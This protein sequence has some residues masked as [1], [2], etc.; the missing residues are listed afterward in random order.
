VVGP[1]FSAAQSQR[2]RRLCLLVVVVLSPDDVDVEGDAGTLGER[3]EDV[4]DHLARQ[5]SDLLA[6]ELQV[7]AEVR[8]RRDVQHRASERLERGRTRVAKERRRRV[9]GL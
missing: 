5:V 3:L 9:S 4:R 8:P 6:L 1:L 2:G 7:A